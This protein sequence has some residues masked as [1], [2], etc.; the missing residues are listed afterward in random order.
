MIHEGESRADRRLTTP[1]PGVYLEAKRSDAQKCAK[2]CRCL[3]GGNAAIE[4]AS[5]LS[6]R[7]AMLTRILLIDE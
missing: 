5:F 3:A 7:Y 2:G 4:M 6:T 1:G